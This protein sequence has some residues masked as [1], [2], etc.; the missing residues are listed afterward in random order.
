[1]SAIYIT[2]ERKKVVD[3]SDPYFA[4]GLVVLTTAGRPDQDA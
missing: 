2:D 4:G 1:M 3:F